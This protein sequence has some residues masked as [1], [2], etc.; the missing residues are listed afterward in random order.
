MRM[1]KAYRC[2]MAGQATGS[3]QSRLYR[4]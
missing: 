4:L 3:L 1:E 2:E